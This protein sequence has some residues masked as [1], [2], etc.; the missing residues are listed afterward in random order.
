MIEQNERGRGRG[1]ASRGNKVYESL[2]EHIRAGEFAPGTR[3]REENVAAMLGVSR[4]PVREALARLQARGLVESSSGGLSVVRLTRPQTMELYALRAILEGAAA[5]FAAENAS[6]SDLVNLR[7]VCERFVAF[8]GGA[9]E[10]ARLNRLYH[11]A[12]YEAAH[13]RYL[14]R[15]LEEL[16][17]WLALLPDTTFSFAGRPA[18]AKEEHRRILLAIEAREPD[19]A[20]KA[21]RGHINHA[22]DARLA[23]LFDRL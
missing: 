7:Y 10:F 20:E 23:L 8:D 12:I 15:M 11:D 14:M 16:H 5:R 21:A 9:S 17:D 6:E 1:A 19:R 3:M 22:R 2:L 13:N 4:T 18:A